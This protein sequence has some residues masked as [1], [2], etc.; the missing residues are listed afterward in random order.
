[1]PLVPRKLE[2]SG[3][4]D[5]LDLLL[6]RRGRDPRRHHEGHVA[7]RLSQRVEHGAEALGELERERLLVN[8]RDLPRM[9]HEELAEAILLSPALERLH[10]VFRQDRL[11]VV[12]SQAVAQRERVLHAI[13]RHGRPIDHLRFDPMVLVRAEEG[14]VHKIA[15]VAR[16]VGGRP[17]RIEDLQ[18]GL[19][20]E[21][22]RLPVLLGVDRRRAQS[23]SDGR[24]R[25]SDDLSATDAAHARVPSLPRR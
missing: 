2:R 10:T 22:Q 17:D 15:V 19:R 23:H 24:G 14:V 16:D 1:L 20:H 18:I 8:G 11:P 9:P 3:A 4:D 7:R 21:A 12:P 13:R 6:R 5:L 25:A